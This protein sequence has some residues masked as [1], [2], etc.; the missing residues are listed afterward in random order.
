MA[1]AP[2]PSGKIV[3]RE[4]TG[5]AIIV[6]VIERVIER[7]EKECDERRE[8]DTRR[9]TQ[10]ERVRSHFGSSRRPTLW[11]EFPFDI[12]PSQGLPLLRRPA[13]FVC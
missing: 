7:E 9:E 5:R 8:R 11:L 4:P 10:E 2:W 12:P 6:I 1:H 3:Q 13:S